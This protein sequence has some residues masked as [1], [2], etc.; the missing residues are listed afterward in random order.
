MNFHVW[1]VFHLFISYLVSHPS[2][3]CDFPVQSHGMYWVALCVYKRSR[4]SSVMVTNESVI[5]GFLHSLNETTKMLSIQAEAGPNRTFSYNTVLVC[6][7]VEEERNLC[8]AINLI[9][10]YSNKICS[11]QWIKRVENERV[12]AMWKKEDVNGLSN[13]DG[14]DYAMANWRKDWTGLFPIFFFYS[15]IEQLY[16]GFSFLSNSDRDEMK[17]MKVS[18][19]QA[20]GKCHSLRLFAFLKLKRIWPHGVWAEWKF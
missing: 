13:V 20:R 11:L 1:P 18:C 16:G 3:I 10:S 15:V 2:S 9:E 6:V 14:D 17:W 5:N 19:C 7:W 4:R 12:E 8:T